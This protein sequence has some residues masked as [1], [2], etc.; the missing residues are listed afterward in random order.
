[1]SPIPAD[2]E[3]LLVAFE[4]FFRAYEAHERAED[5]FAQGSLNGMLLPARV[6]S[7][8]P[9]FR[10][11]A[12]RLLAHQGAARH[13]LLFLRQVMDQA[14]R[15]L[16]ESPQELAYADLLALG[17]ADPGQE[18]RRLYLLALELDPGCARAHFNL[19]CLLA[20]EG[21]TD[22]AMRHFDTAGEAEDWYRKYAD[23]RVGLLLDSAGKSQ[24]AA[25]RL[26]RAMGDGHDS[27]GQLRNR[28]GDAM[29]RAGD[30]S[31]ALNHYARALDWH[32]Y[33]PPEF[34]VTDTPDWFGA[35]LGESRAAFCSAAPAP[36]QAPP[37]GKGAKPWET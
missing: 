24:E 26:R 10:R 4:A 9:L 1:M 15:L 30:A 34:A 20:D 19:A 3:R 8:E 16:G 32:H 5:A 18:A 28:L 23:L 7:F 27:F 31:A 13:K 33:F 36:G 37:P 2:A 29:R 25:V 11:A 14:M 21:R 35:L 22:E 17:G 6:R 12:A